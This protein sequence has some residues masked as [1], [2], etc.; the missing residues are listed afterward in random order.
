MSTPAFSVHPTGPVG[1]WS[2]TCLQY[3]VHVRTG[4]QYRYCIYVCDTTTQYHYA[5]V[6]IVAPS[7][8]YFL[9]KRRKTAE[10]VI[11]HDMTVI[12]AVLE[13]CVKHKSKRD[14]YKRWLFIQYS[15][16]LEDCQSVV[17][18]CSMLLAADLA[19]R[20]LHATSFLTS[21]N[22]HSLYIIFSLAE[23]YFCHFKATA[24]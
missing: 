5:R 19:K 15:V 10:P 4:T 13:Y 8:A 1:I 9:F 6:N 24:A 2:H 20:R 11:L 14:S 12:T 18:Y 22:P 16:I 21:L 23:G 3:C 7:G 17:R